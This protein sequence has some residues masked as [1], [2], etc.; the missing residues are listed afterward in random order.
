MN[1]HTENS[2]VKSDILRSTENS[3]IPHVYR[4]FQLISKG[5]KEAFHQLF[6][7]YAPFSVAIIKKII[8]T[9]EQAEDILQEV[10][11]KLW[12]KRESLPSVENPKA[13]IARITCYLCYNWLRHEKYC[14]KANTQIKYLLPA[15]SNEVEEAIG[16][17]ET[18]DNLAKAVKELPPQT[19]M[20]FKLNKEQG[21]KISEIAD[22]LQL[23]PQTVKNT[24]GT[25]LKKV[26]AYL[27]QQGLTS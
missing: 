13:W 7:L 8:G 1:K 20:I 27:R 3:D 18:T 5:D 17:T 21:M 9:G 14:E 16:F 10:F 23:S 12:L 6:N 4:L 15:Y 2:K 11:L 22:Y 26:K 25:A 24:L 19:R